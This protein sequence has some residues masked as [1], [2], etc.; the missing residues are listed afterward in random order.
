[1]KR[2]HAAAVWQLSIIAFI[3]GCVTSNVATTP[4]VPEPL[5]VPPGQILIQQVHATGVQIY[6]CT[7]SKDNPVRFEWTLKAPEAELRD[8]ANRIFGRHYAGPTW[9][10]F[11]GSRVV[12]EV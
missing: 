4:S 2:I 11:D 1:M 8:R 9:E 7:A 10:A 3:T 5:R 6:E 12:G